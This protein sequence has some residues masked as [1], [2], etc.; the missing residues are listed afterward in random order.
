[1]EE[2]GGTPSQSQAV[3]ILQSK[4][5]K[6]SI[7]E[8]YAANTATVLGGLHLLCGVV[9]LVFYFVGLQNFM[10]TPNIIIGFLP[11]VFFIVMGSVAIAGARTG[12]TCLVVTT[13]VMTIL[14]AVLAGFRLIISTIFYFYTQSI[15]IMISAAL[16]VTGV[17]S[18]ALACRP[19]CCRPAAST[20]TVSYN[21][22]QTVASS[23]LLRVEHHQHTT[24]E[25][26]ALPTGLCT[27]AGDRPADHTD[28]PEGGANYQRF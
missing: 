13:L 4:A 2:G 12:N 25:L 11:S 17:V 21:P 20:G 6:P 1:M 23:T 14:S 27:R 7:K 10:L 24:I 22:E 5:P 15:F 8:T 9:A 18:A 28:V 16:V 19:L 26:P 3:Y